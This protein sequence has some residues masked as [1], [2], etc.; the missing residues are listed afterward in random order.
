MGYGEIRGHLRDVL[1][2]QQ[3][4]TGVE[5]PVHE[6]VARLPVSLSESARAPDSPNQRRR[7]L[8]VGYAVEHGLNI[9]SG[10]SCQHQ[11][12]RAAQKQG[13]FRYSGRQ[14][15]P[16][17]LGL[18]LTSGKTYEQQVAAPGEERVPPG[19]ELAQFRV[20]SPTLYVVE[21]KRA[22]R[23]LRSGPAVRPA[24]VEQLVSPHLFDRPEKLRL[25]DGLEQIGPR[26][27]LYGLLGVLELIVAADYNDRSLRPESPAALHERDAVHVRHPDV[28]DE[29][30]GRDALHEPHGLGPAGRGSYLQSAGPGGQLLQHGLYTLAD[31]LHVVRHYDLQHFTTPQAQCRCRAAS[32]TPLPR[33]SL[34]S[35]A[36]APSPRR[37]TSRAA[38]ARSRCL[39]RCAPS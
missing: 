21:K 23:L 1:R 26:P 32:H 6:D 8:E 5:Q 20:F 10:G 4:L 33:P 30:V 12:L 34:R 2:R 16:E 15:P 9:A 39:C 27:V 35:P 36:S 31:H 38:G 3:T 19:H 7:E 24:G 29:Q 13:I 17:R 22:A 18:G 14:S 11:L 28:R 25:V 37:R